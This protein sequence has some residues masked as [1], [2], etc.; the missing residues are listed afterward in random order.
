MTHTGSLTLAPINTPA[1]PRKAGREGAK[2]DGIHQL[3]PNCPSWNVSGRNHKL[4]EKHFLF[5]TMQAQ[6]LSK[7]S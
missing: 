4:R 5:G 1:S 7:D 6:N 3:G 2:Q